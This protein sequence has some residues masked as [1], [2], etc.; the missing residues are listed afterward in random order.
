[1]YFQWSTLIVGVFGRAYICMVMY[2]SMYGHSDILYIYYN[3]Y[4]Y[5]H[6][7]NGQMVR[8]AKQRGHAV[9]YGCKNH[10]FESRKYAKT[11]HGI[12]SRRP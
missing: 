5:I 7:H 3:M 6:T 4:I 1:M 10:G 2:V 11:S 9:L 12:S 8:L